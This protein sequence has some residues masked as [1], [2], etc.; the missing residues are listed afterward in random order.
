MGPR[1]VLRAVIAGDMSKFDEECGLCANT[2]LP[3]E[4]LHECAESWPEFSG[5]RDF[6]VPHPELSPDDAYFTQPL[7]CGE[8]GEARKRYA[9]HILSSMYEIR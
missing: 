7:Y 6:P 1:E 2:G 4:F 3:D 8:Y 9:W 5:D